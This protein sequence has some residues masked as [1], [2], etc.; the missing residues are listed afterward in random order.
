MSERRL[1]VQCTTRETTLY[2]VVLDRHNRLVWVPWNDRARLD[3]GVPYVL[4][5]TT[6]AA[7]AGEGACM[8]VETTVRSELG[9]DA[10]KR[11][12]DGSAM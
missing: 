4:G 8:V 12:A 6:L 5:T 1:V 2:V 11:R 10:S 7:D 3:I 9:P